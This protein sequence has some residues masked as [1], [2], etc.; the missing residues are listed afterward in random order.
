MPAIALRVLRAAVLFA[1]L[2][3]AC[4]TPGPAATRTPVPRH[5][6]PPQAAVVAHAPALRFGLVGRPRGVNGWSLFDESGASYPDYAVRSGEYPTLYRLSV[7]GWEFEPYVADGMPSAVSQQG[8]FYVASVK[9]Q[10]G[11]YWSDGSALTSADVAFSANTALAFHLGLDWA[12]A[13]DPDLLDHVGS[14]DGGTVTFFFKRPFNVGDWQYGTLQGAILNQA[15]W[16]PKM[17]EARSRLPAPDLLASLAKARSE[18]DTLEA[19]IAAD[20]A[21]LLKTPSGSAD[22][23]ELA[24]RIKRNQDDLNAAGARVQKY[25]DQADAALSAARSSLFAI[26]DPNEPTFG[27]FLRAAQT[28]DVFTRQANP[29]Y[30]FV[31]PNYDRLE[32][33]VFS[34]TASA[35]AAFKQG[36]VDVLLGAGGA[37]QDGAT[38]W[39]ATS[40]A[41][42]LVFNPARKMLAGPALHKA[43]SCLIDTAAILPGRS[44]P[45]SGFV[46][47]GPWQME[48]PVSICAGL[49]RTQRIQNAVRLM[50]EAGY[51][52]AQPPGPETA[53]SGL[54]LP[55]G[56]PF[57]PITLLTLSADFDPAR[58]GAA[59]YV[60]SQAR[61][62]GIPLSYKPVDPDTLHYTIYSTRDYDL[63]ILGWRLSAYP[64]YL[65]QW[66]QPAGPFANSSQALQSACQTMNGTADLETARQAAYGVQSVLMKELPFIPLY[67]E[68][69]FE[70]QRNLV[71]PWDRLLDGLSA[72]Y[73]APGL[74]VPSP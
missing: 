46:L 73:G 34:D 24:A 23:A 31:K 14:G 71:Y 66:F 39:Y 65:C 19:R 25:Q 9:L 52:W 28:G 36:Q 57:P 53:G 68:A 48:E 13:Y 49:P 62:L 5:S 74:A 18:A 10:S 37:P 32:Y 69:R 50:T 45:L 47:P 54:A 59:G 3:G 20:N 38:S 27:P 1:L 43:L 7:P 63:A 33:S 55:E 29:S 44:V 16:S 51:S 58:A 64:G 11:L 72:C 8:D 30:P 17:T 35:A 6:S 60:E 15:Y 61:F 2:S 67:Q 70:M 42:F 22:H 4:S 21:L 41:R 26:P 40:S 56:G 12:S